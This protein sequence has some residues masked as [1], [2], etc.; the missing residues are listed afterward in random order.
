M[1]GDSG[2]GRFGSG[3]KRAVKWAVGM[4]LTPERPPR[5]Q[6]TS[7]HPPE[8]TGASPDLTEDDHSGSE[9]KTFEKDG[10]SYLIRDEWHAGESS[11]SHRSYYR[12]TTPDPSHSRS[13][14][15]KENERLAYHID[16]QGPDARPRHWNNDSRA[17]LRPLTSI[18]LD[19]YDQD[20]QEL[21]SHPSSERRD[22]IN[23]QAWNDYSGPGRNNEYSDERHATQPIIRR[24]NDQDKSRP[25][26]REYHNPERQ[27]HYNVQPVQ[28][29]TNTGVINLTTKYPDI[30]KFNNSPSDATTWMEF[31]ENYELQCRA[32]SVPM[33]SWPRLLPIYLSEGA[34][35]TY[36]NLV[37][38]QPE[39]KD[40]YEALMYE[41]NKEFQNSGAASP[42]DLYSR[43]KAANESVGKFYSVI[44]SMAK[45]LYPNMD[46]QARDKVILGAF[47]AG[48]PISF[49]R[50]LLNKNLTSA[51]E[52]FKL[53]QRYERTN[54]I[55]LK[56]GGTTVAQPVT[57][58][59]NQLSAD[60]KRDHELE[61]L[62]NSLKE[63]QRKESERA[64]KE[65]RLV[66][67]T[68]RER[69]MRMNN[70]R[71]GYNNNYGYNNRNNQS[72]HNR[73]HDNRRQY[74]NYED[75]RGFSNQRWNN[76]RQPH[77]Y[78]QNRNGNNYRLDANYQWNDNH[79]NYRRNANYSPQNRFN[80]AR[81]YNRN[82]EG[83]DFTLNA[84]PI[85]SNCGRTGHLHYTCRHNPQNDHG[86]N[87]NRG[88]HAGNQDNYVQFVDVGNAD[89]YIQTVR[90]NSVNKL[91]KLLDRELPQSSHHDTED[92]TMP[93]DE[94]ML[95][96]AHFN[97]ST[98]QTDRD[99]LI[100][101]MYS[102][103]LSPMEEDD[104]Q[105]D[106]TLEDWINQF[107]TSLNEEEVWISD[108]ES[109]SNLSNTNHQD[110]MHNPP[111]KE[112]GYTDEM[113]SEVE[114]SCNQELPDGIHLG[115]ST[116][117]SG[118][119]RRK[120]KQSEINEKPEEKPRRYNLRQRKPT[121][122]N[123]DH[124]DDTESNDEGTAGQVN[125]TE[126]VDLDCRPK[127]YR[128]F[129]GACNLSPKM[130]LSTLLVM[131]LITGIST[132][133][134][135]ICAS[136]DII[137]ASDKHM[138]SS[139]E[140][141]CGRFNESGRIGRLDRQWMISRKTGSKPVLGHL[142]RTIEIT[143]RFTCDANENRFR[144]RRVM[145]YAG[146]TQQDCWTRMVSQNWSRYDTR[147]I[148]GGD[149]I[150]NGV[151]P[152]CTDRNDT[153][154]IYD[155]IDVIIQPLGFRGDCKTNN[156]QKGDTHSKPTK[157]S[158]LISPQ[159]ITVKQRDTQCENGIRQPKSLAPE[160]INALMSK[161]VKKVL[162][163]ERGKLCHHYLLIGIHR[164]TRER[165]G[166]VFVCKVGE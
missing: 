136:T 12:D 150:I 110:E 58:M 50:G 83:R 40:D 143:S 134:Y 33:Q 67:Q 77:S 132:Q 155:V 89:Q 160:E 32:L 71:Q 20:I 137:T 94:E 16:E 75:N 31:R 161:G 60:I 63:L 56:D 104:L 127:H 69:N 103:Y 72:S 145:K 25:M 57:E 54:E 119:D 7:T 10:E 26:H 107:P 163:Y 98:R 141:S 149:F 46:Y 36:K 102:S 48:L 99:M 139:T 113:S 115:N 157:A 4:P 21:H 24:I 15:N 74:R 87:Q 88:R 92:N 19:N 53:A 61:T 35:I 34:L 78:N 154:L 49:K 144:E 124:W 158:R 38:K 114:L 43:Q 3:V 23:P 84:A 52:A 1:D 51:E 37:E 76:Q 8:E 91:E 151:N 28:Q 2:K 117:A 97:S 68:Q 39:L 70:P 166:G 62:R 153:R 133:E 109:N 14:E 105:P 142:C 59:V 101:D 123:A 41:L 9:I 126:Q 106:I 130:A 147:L 11:G 22:R 90:Q 165:K 66:R 95:W 112:N 44:T 73:Y 6:K 81:E 18:G 64:E 135:I 55:I 125:R 129:K 164:C 79:T 116:P 30:D 29:M 118:L 156:T 100:A 108:D 140:L 131:A 13:S 148:S 138:D 80:N 146:V 45:R 121:L 86:Q 17:P 82:H 47:L 152:E 120:E 111:Q 162:F 96:N 42:V 128:K 27:Q 93:S 159:S 85:C 5:R 65:D 122:Y